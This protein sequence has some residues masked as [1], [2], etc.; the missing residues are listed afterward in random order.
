MMRLLFS[1]LLLSNFAPLFA[2]KTV[3]RMGTLAPKGSAWHKILMQMSQDVRKQ[4]DGQVMIRLYP[5]GV[6]GDESEMI[7]KMRIGQL[8]AAA[9]SNGGLGEIEPAAY[10]V[11]V[12]MMFNDYEE[13]DYVRQRV[14]DELGEALLKKKFVVLAWSDVGWLYFFSKNKMETPD[15]MKKS[16]MASSASESV[17]GDIFKWAGFN[18]VPITTVDLISGMQTGLVNSCFLPIMIAEGTQLYRYAPNM[19]NLPWAPLQGAVVLSRKAWDKIPE[20]HHPTIRRIADE[21]GKKLREAARAQE[22]SSLEAM[23]KRG[24]N[25]TGIS[26]DVVESWRRVTESAWPRIRSNLVPADM[27]DRVRKLRDEFRASKASP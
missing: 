13:W 27:F 5:G 12:P 15:Q 23:K 26:G 14:N 8:Q 4:T 1:I 24:L 10:A 22:V 20:Q 9:I 11:S 18:P 16:K 7:R 17:M 3:I 19:I 6:V 2:G 21:A 25:V